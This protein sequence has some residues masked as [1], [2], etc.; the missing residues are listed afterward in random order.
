MS[1]T[2][3]TQK[4]EALIEAMREMGTSEVRTFT[5]TL[6]SVL[7]EKFTPNEFAS[8]ISETKAAMGFH[9]PGDEPEDGEDLLCLTCQMTAIP[10]RQL[11][12]VLYPNTGGL[13]RTFAVFEQNN[14]VAFGFAGNEVCTALSD[15][16][17]LWYHTPGGDVLAALR[18]IFGTELCKITV[19]EEESHRKESLPERV[20]RVLRP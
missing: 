11:R 18:K 10:E 9:Q 4:A 5:A 16:P 1:R 13:L 3:E 14:L 6:I 12:L 19:E 7:Q 2:P 15:R 17:S 20:R 8:A